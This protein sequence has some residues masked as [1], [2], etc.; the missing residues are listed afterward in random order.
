MPN[1][2]R[3]GQLPQAHPAIALETTGRAIANDLSFEFVHP[4]TL[5]PYP[6]T[7]HRHP[8]EQIA[9]LRTS[10]RAHGVVGAVITDEDGEIINGEAVWRAAKAEGKISIPV[11]RRHGLSDAQKRALRIGLNKHAQNAEWDLDQLRI[12]IQGILAVNIDFDPGEIGMSSG[13]IDKLLI[14]G[15]SDPED[16]AIPALAPRAVS[17]SGDIWIASPHRLGCGSCLDGNF[18]KRVVGDRL[19]DCCITD[20]PFNRKI[21][22]GATTG[23]GRIRHAEFAMASGEMS[24]QAYE[25]FLKD[26]LGGC[27]KVSRDGAVHFICMD[28]Q[29]LEILLAV[30]E[31][32]YSRRLNICVWSKSNAGM[33]GLYRNQHELVCVFTVGEAPYFNAVQL[34]KYGRNRTNV[35]N[36]PSVNTFGGSRRR[37]L[38]LHPTV[39]PVALV[40]DAIMDVTRR[41]D[42]VLDGFLGSGTCLL[43]CERTGRICRGVEIDPL[44]VDLALQ[45]WSERTGLEPVLELTGQTFTQV[46]AERL[47]GEV[48]NV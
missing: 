18:L 14:V 41:G 2:S 3:R 28:H 37:D 30:G 8:K 32:V 45:R 36:Y 26:S 11:I 5:K 47:G 21:I 13:E 25:H 42:L 33:G 31:E 24:A 27:A 44:Y 43:A 6:G 16:D 19:V 7:A 35:W 17:Q 9:Q 34:G 29:H 22:G 23:R 12:E 4:D 39:K 38:E 1:Q 15:D 46:R 48:A 40:A 20:P 10:I